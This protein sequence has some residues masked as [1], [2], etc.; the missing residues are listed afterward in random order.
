MGHLAGALRKLDTPKAR[1]E[2]K[3]H[4]HGAFAIE[5]SKDII[6]LSSMER[7]LGSLLDVHYDTNDA[8]GLVRCQEPINIGLENLHRRKVD[9]L[10]A[11]SYATL[12][13]RVAQVL[14]AHSLEAN[15]QGALALL[16][17]AI[18]YAEKAV[19]AP[20]R[21]QSSET[22][23]LLEKLLQS[24]SGGAAEKWLEG[25]ED[26]PTIFTPKAGNQEIP[27]IDAKKL[28]LNLREQAERLQS[29]FTWMQIHP[30]DSSESMEPWELVEDYYE[31]LD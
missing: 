16:N 2:A 12:L 9:T 24:R 28:L 7:L 19:E 14:S 1:E 5:C 26:E 22:M 17:E 18:T 20:G 29:G 15:R 13:Q 11:A 27:N 4:L 8:A 30:K 23:R 10:E 3:D 21:G 6:K 25:L 31:L